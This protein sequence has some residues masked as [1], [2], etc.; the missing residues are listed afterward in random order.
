MPP[1]ERTK[2]DPTLEDLLAKRPDEVPSRTM[3][4][5]RKRRDKYASEYNRL[6]TSVANAFLVKQLAKLAR[7][8]GVEV[9]YRDKK[10]DIVPRILDMWGWQMPLPA[11]TSSSR[12]LQVR[13]RSC[14][15]SAIR[16]ILTKETSSYHRQNYSCSCVI[17]RPC[18][19]SSKSQECLSRSSSRT[20]GRR[21]RSQETIWPS[22]ANPRL[23]RR[24]SSGPLRD[25]AD[26]TYSRRAHQSATSERAVCSV[27]TRLT[28]RRT[29]G[30]SV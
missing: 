6:H 16:A 23:S 5:D 20:R 29:S 4:K 2:A 19:N 28:R 7:E 1:T 8:M 21:L 24:P 17:P 11:S 12:A 27:V 3:Q 26:S 25:S 9:G 10:A 22:R 15:R 13:G 14:Y 18:G 30:K